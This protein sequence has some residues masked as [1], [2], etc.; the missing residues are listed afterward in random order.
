MHPD[1][2]LCMA[3]PHWQCLESR[4]EENGLIVSPWLLVKRRKVPQ[5]GNYSVMP[6]C[7]PKLKPSSLEMEKVDKETIELIRKKFHALDVDKDGVLDEI[8]D[9]RA[10]PPGRGARSRN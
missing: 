6:E 5:H 10:A 9:G 2:C 1:D 3:I 7:G 8:A 4:L